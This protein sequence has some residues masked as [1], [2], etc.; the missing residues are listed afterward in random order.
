MST[1]AG[2]KTVNFLRG[3]PA[4][5]ALEQLV[6]LVSSGYEKAVRRYGTDVL[7]Y[8]HFTGFQPLRELIARMHG[9]TPERVIAGNGGMEVISLF[10]KSLP[11]R[12]EILIEE[13]TYD[14]VVIDAQRYG[15]KVTGVPMGPEGVAL[16]AFEK[17]V[18]STAAAA[19]YGIPFHHNPTGVTYT[20]ENR[21]AVEAVCRK[22]DLLCAWD[23]C[24]EALRYDGS[25]NEPVAVSDW[26]PI[27]F[28]SFTK[29]ITPGTK[30]GYMV[31][32]RKLVDL[33]TNVLSNTRLNPN[34]PSQAFISEFIAAG[35]YAEFLNTL[36]RLY[37][38]RM[39][40]LNAALRAHF[41]GRG[42]PE[43]TGGFFATLTLNGIN[44][45]NEPAFISAARE[46]GVNVSAAWDAVAPNLREAKRNSGLFIRLTFPA[47]EPE[48][49]SWGISKLKDVEESFK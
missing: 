37:R 13:T 49:I 10:F 16:D 39:D 31:V 42:S 2:S 24:Y 9:V 20:P 29:T 8:G 22:N 33:L 34:L 28:S 7:Q 23:I 36:R 6:A 32:P 5:E 19:F 1:H 21:K 30:C 38:P 14:R 3:V 26:G 45:D 47:C 43:I 27:L 12:S 15:H 48:M 4:D 25:P 35:A 40:A 44:R 46:A 41:P 18:K 11:A 17:Q